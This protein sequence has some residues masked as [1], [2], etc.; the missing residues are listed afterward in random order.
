MKK[1]YNS[2]VKQN[3]LSKVAAGEAVGAVAKATGVSASNIYAW[4]AKEKGQSLNIQKLNKGTPIE[5][6]S[7]LSQGVAALAG[8]AVALQG[9]VKRLRNAL[10]RAEEERDILKKATAYFAAQTI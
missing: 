4:L 1:Q 8:D 9:E 3:A 6:L 7:K 5:G 10:K 2:D